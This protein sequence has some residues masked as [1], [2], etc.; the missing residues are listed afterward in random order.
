MGDI[1]IV[2]QEMGHAII[3]LPEIANAAVPPL[4]QFTGVTSI[5]NSPTPIDT[6]PYTDLFRDRLLLITRLKLRFVEKTLP[7]LVVA[8]SKKAKK[9]AAAAPAQNTT[10]PDYQILAELRGRYDADLYRIQVEFVDLHSGN[11]LINNLYS[12]RKEAQSSQQSAESPA[13]DSTYQHL[14]P[15]DAQQPP[16]DSGTPPPVASPAGVQ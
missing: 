16:A 6:Q 3:D 1:T 15:P 9:A 11:V 5:I 12:I 4:V 13:D 14:P 2:G 8:P 7:P 10:N